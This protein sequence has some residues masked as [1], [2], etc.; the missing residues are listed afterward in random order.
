[1][2]ILTF[3]DV[4]I[5]YDSLPA[6]EKVSFGVNEGEFFCI[7]GA[8]GSGKSTLLKAALGLVPLNGGTIGFAVARERISYVPQINT[9]ERNFPATVREIVM[10]GT[11]RQGHRLPFH[12]QADRN[13]AEE[14][15]AL[16]E[17]ADLAGTQIGKLSGGQQQRVML[18]R[19]MCRRPSL[20][21]LDEPCSA[22]DSDTQNIFYATLKRL[23]REN[24]LSIVMV[25][26]DFKGMETCAD[27]I[28]V[29]DRKLIFLGNIA[30]WSSIRLPA[31]KQKKGRPE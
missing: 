24:R 18:A 21:I 29:L 10:T 15:M 11:Q 16:F 31:D 6:V 27:R 9:G 20:L 7:A 2:A 22:L 8:N 17:I 3:D 30:D 26:H 12:T 25:S 1:M 19:A 13:A 5:V 14:A 28:A 4:T 23:N